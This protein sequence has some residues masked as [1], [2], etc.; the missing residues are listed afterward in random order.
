M[1]SVY[2]KSVTVLGSTGSVGTQALDVARSLELKVDAITGATRIDILED[3]I[4]GFKPSVCAVL[5]EDR[6]RELALKVADTS[7]KVVGGYDAIVDIA[8][9]GVSDSV[10]NSIT[11]KAGLRPSLA[12]IESG[13]SLALANKE[14]IVCAGELV[15]KALAEKNVKILPVDSEHS[16]IFQSIANNR[17]GDISKVILTASGGPFYGKTRDELA[18]I[19]PEMALAHPTWK[20]G[21]KITIDSA[22]LMNKGFE[23]IEAK[24]LF[25]VEPSQIDVIVHPESIVHSMVEYIDKAV[26]AQLSCPDMRL[27][28]Q[29][30]LSYPN[31]CAGTLK[32]LDLTEVGSLTFKKPDK[33]T[34]KLLGLAYDV[35]NRGGNLG[36]AL[37][38]ANERAVA[39][40]LDKR[41]SF[42]DIMDLVCEAVDKIA[43]IEDPTLDDIEQTDIR[44]RELI[45]E[46]LRS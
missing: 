4:R 18:G 36:A 23:V 5:D 17:H 14:T 26:L 2:E 33:K 10:I 34:F 16:A 25:D 43:Y 22:T 12:V 24:Y 11:G 8:G 3:Q 21:P 28:V 9:Q 39:L 13:V 30:A 40:F 6:A 29:Y 37:N 46:L 1:K 42:T 44:S 27:C 32:P 7:C 41:I 35:L 45:D 15:N 31:R 38:G 20:M 19:T